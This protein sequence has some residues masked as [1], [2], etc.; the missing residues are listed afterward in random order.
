MFKVKITSSESYRNST[1]PSV[2]KSLAQE[3]C[4][5][6]L[7]QKNKIFFNGEAEVSKLIGGEYNGRRG[8]DLSIDVG[9]DDKIFV[10][11]ESEPSGF[12]DELDSMRGPTTPLLWEDPLT[13]SS[14]RPIFEGKRYTITINKYFKD[15]VQAE[16][17]RRKIRSAILGEH[18]NTLFDLDTHFP[19][20]MEILACYQEIYNRL[21]N[22]KAVDP[23]DSNFI[24]WFRQNSFV[25]TDIISNLIGN[26]D[27]LV[28]KQQMADNGIDHGDV[29]IAK[30]NKGRYIGQYEVSWSYSYHWNEHTEWEL[31]YPIQV[32]QQPMG[33]EWM[34]DDFDNNK[35]S[36]PTRRFLESKLASMVFDYLDINTNNYIC[37]PSQDNWRPPSI[38]WIAP[39][40]QILINLEDVPGEQVLLNVTQIQGFDWDPT[41]LHFVLKYHKKVTK[42]HSSPLNFKLFSSDTEVMESDIEL[43]ENGDL[44]LLRPGYL[45]SIY[46]L[47]F[48]FD[49]AV[50]LFDD[51][52]IEDLIK[53][54][55]YG[56]LIIDTLFP[57]Y[58]L[59]S[60]WGVD[61][62]KDWGHIYDN[63][64]VGDGELIEEFS[65]YMM[66]L[67]IIAHRQR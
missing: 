64:D 24:K 55:E 42:R 51:G 26:N 52:C 11:F 3:L 30:V 36:Y 66:G 13:G 45:R 4:Y 59:P 60:D 15:R 56:K 50:R 58:Q 18:L 47:T 31:S 34:P 49:T 32:Y 14:I 48:N 44:V 25:P 10:E 29:Q 22:A 17:F 19:I 6:N 28:F 37:L 54:P 46:R 1:R 21:V 39:Q 23:V 41:F 16:S 5:F 61:G 40:L 27:C 57:D 2:F 7:H 62:K 8:S 12:N 43:R 63:I 9:Y 65:S 33:I 53:D 38:N 67:G 35:R 20:P